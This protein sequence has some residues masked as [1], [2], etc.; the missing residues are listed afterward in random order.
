MP[1]LRQNRFTKE[2]VIVATER[3][4]RPEELRVQRDSRPPLPH[5]SET[6]PF[7][8]GNERLALDVDPNRPDTFLVDP[9][10]RQWMM[11]ARWG[12]LISSSAY[13]ALVLFGI[14]EKIIVGAE[15]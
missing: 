13:M 12:S 15:Q 4:K 14:S 1:E 9:W 10:G 6:C 11:L 3:A 2:W 5:Y 8:P 7:C